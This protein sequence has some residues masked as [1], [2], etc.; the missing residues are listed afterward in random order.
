MNIEEFKRK[1]SEIEFAISSTGKK[2]T[3]IEVNKDFIEFV[4]NE[5][6]TS[7]RISTAELFDFYKSEENYKT[8]TAKDYISGRVQSPSVAILNELT[9]NHTKTIEKDKNDKKEKTI[10]NSFVEKKKEFNRQNINVLKDETKFF[11]ALS[12]LIGVEYIKSKSIEKP[13]SSLDVFL[14]NNFVDYEFNADVNKCYNEILNKLTSNKL[15][16][17]ESLSHHID[18]LIINH[19]ILKNRIV[20]FDEEQ[21]FTPARKDCL[22]E[23]KAILPDTYLSKSI[24]ICDNIEYLNNVVLKKHRIK[25][26]LKNSPKTFKEFIDWLNKSGEKKSGYISEKNGFEYLGGRIAQRA[27]YDCLRD[28]AHLSNKNKTLKSPLRFPKKWFE[29]KTK[30]DFKYIPV[31]TLVKLIEKQLID[32]YNIKPSA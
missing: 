18:G 14:S 31:E 2:Y 13:I 30:Q 27:Y 1:I 15:F 6:K 22:K 10:T 26:K 3:I 20:E 28:T 17:S 29:E 25:N 9:R 12:Q 32:D 19:P 11:V 23:L 21:H 16:S 4:R 7:E 8:T 5:K 24:E